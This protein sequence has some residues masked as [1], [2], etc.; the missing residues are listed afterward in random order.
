MRNDDIKTK[1]I[2]NLVATLPAFGAAD[3]APLGEK[4]ASLNIILSRQ[5]KRGTMV[6]LRRNLYVT[7]SYLDTAERR[8][9]FSDYVEFA[10]NTLYRPSYLSLDYVLHEHN[11]LTEIPRNITSVGLR[12]TEQLSNDLG[13][14][15]YHKIKEELFV[16]FN[17][18]KK[19][20]FSICKAT[21]AK[22]LFDF[23]YFRKR[24]L[25][26]KRA[27]EELRLNLDEFSKSDFTELAGYLTLE[28]S[29]RMKE[30]INWLK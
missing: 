10:A 7:R 30:I 6:R 18:I 22:A 20:N 29:P 19:G 5:M 16:G 11:M 13:I 24:L 26:D 9:F 15:I 4:K 3:L 21:K 28:K 12:K 25:V 23:L 14:F 1:R 8:G 17:M 27:V 2:L